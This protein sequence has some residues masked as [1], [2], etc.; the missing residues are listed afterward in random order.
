MTN[1]IAAMD[2]ATSSTSKKKTSSTSH[3]VRTMLMK[4]KAKGDTKRVPKI[5]DRF[6]LELVVISFFEGE[7]VASASFDFL[8]KI[9]P[10]GRLLRDCV[11]IPT[12]FEATVLVPTEKGGFRQV[13]D[14]ISLQDA[15]KM[16]FFKSF[17]R[18]VVRI[19]KP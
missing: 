8:A 14:D 12:G 4:S 16:G 13:P 5:D 1:A 3:K 19:Y 15:E 18:A 7:C 17:D 6:F 2:E 9:D 10:V 11:S